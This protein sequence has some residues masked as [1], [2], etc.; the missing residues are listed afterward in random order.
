MRRII[1][2]L[3]SFLTSVA[4]SDIDNF[5]DGSSLHPCIV[6]D[7]SDDSKAVKNLR[8]MMNITQIWMSGSGATTIEGWKD[9]AA[10]IKKLTEGKVKYLINV[11][12]R[13]ESHG[14]LNGQAINL[15][16]EFNWINK[17]KNAQQSL[18]DEKNWLEELKKQTIIPNVLTSK[19][20]KN[21]DFEGQSIPVLEVSTEKELTEQLGFNYVRLTVTDHM[22]PR[23]NDVDRFVKLIDQLPEASWVHIHCRAGE[24]RTTTFMA[25]YDMLRNA[26]QVSFDDI[27]KRQASVT[28]YYDLSKFDRKN[29]SLR[30]V[31]YARYVFLKRFYQFANERLKGN[32]QTWSQWNESHAQ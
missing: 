13:E 3:F 18:R 21:N 22:A 7:T 23:S 31:Y 16:S 10:Y 26:D 1:F 6:Q 9:L 25:M 20:F 17:G 8:H 27:I 19:Q 2:I 14:F 15:T 12:L 11:D 24:G 32:T 29:P 5:C 4:Y 30:D 28:P